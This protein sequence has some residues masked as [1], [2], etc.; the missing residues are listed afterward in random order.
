MDNTHGKKA[1][2][3]VLIILVRMMTVRLNEA[4]IVLSKCHPISP[5]P[6]ILTSG[7]VNSVIVFH[8]LRKLSKRT[9]S[10]DNGQIRAYNEHSGAVERVYWRDYMVRADLTSYTEEK[11]Y[12]HGSYGTQD[13]NQCCFSCSP[14]P[15]FLPPT[16]SSLFSFFSSLFLLLL[17]LLLF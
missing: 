3:E 9:R 14:P 8:W 11:R 2:V 12:G 17:F 7:C 13:L 10:Q 16:L 5:A 15:P 6:W 1:T 4:K